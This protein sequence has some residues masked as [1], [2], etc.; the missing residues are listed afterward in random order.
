MNVLQ[1]ISTP[2]QVL[3]IP[4]ENTPTVNLRLSNEL[5]GDS[6]EYEL[7]TTYD[8]GFMTVELSHPFNE[9]DNYSFEV[10]HL[11]G[12][13]LYR[14]KIYITAQTDLENYKPNPDFL[15]A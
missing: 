11:A 10:F 4:R 12:K 1:P 3:F 2:Q 15:Y 13:S 14:G 5:K 6:T 7:S 9:A 8:N